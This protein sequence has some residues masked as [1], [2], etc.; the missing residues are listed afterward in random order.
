MKKIINVIL[1]AIFFLVKNASCFSQQSTDG[2]YLFTMWLFL[3]HVNQT[4]RTEDAF[5]IKDSSVFSLFTKNIN[6]HLDTLKST[7]FP[8]SYLFLALNLHDSSLIYNQSTKYLNYIGIPSFC[9]RYVLCVNEL[10]GK[11]F[12]IQGF[13]GNDFFSLLKDLKNDVY[14]R[15]ELR[16]TTK[17]FI[18]NYYVEGID[19]KCI[20]KGLLSGEY[21]LHKYPCLYDCVGSNEIIWTN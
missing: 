7:G 4:Y 15:N 20:Y 1:F 12:R 5:P 3:E 11:S 9:S 18:K 17:S 19:F 8:D 10:N 14:R 21:D 6:F 16:L 2:K 13:T